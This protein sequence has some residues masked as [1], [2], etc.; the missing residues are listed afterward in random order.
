MFIFPEYNAIQGTLLFEPIELIDSEL[1]LNIDA[2]YSQYNIDKE[3]PISDLQKDINEGNNTYSVDNY[4]IILERMN[5]KN[6]EYVFVLHGENTQ[7]PYTPNNPYYNRVDVS[8][9]IKLGG[10]NSDNEYVMYEPTV[11]KSEYYGTDIVFYTDE[12]LKDPTLIIDN[13]YIKIPEIVVPINTNL[14]SAEPTYMVESEE[15]LI[16]SFNSRL[17]YASGEIPKEEITGFSDEE[18]N[19]LDEKYIPET[20]NESIGFSNNEFSYYYGTSILTQYVYEEDIIAIVVDTFITI[21]KNGNQKLETD[22]HKVTVTTDNGEM[23]IVD[24]EILS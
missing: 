17:M 9:D 1:Y 14:M 3:I 22:T 7:L 4:D 20:T 18:L 8:F 15:F 10:Y 2:L 12:T 6:N 11:E 21:D 13:L 5:I 16:E 24:D 19:D 23:L